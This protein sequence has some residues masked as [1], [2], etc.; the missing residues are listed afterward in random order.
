MNRTGVRGKSRILVALGLILGALL[1]VGGLQAQPGER[2]FY[3]ALPYGSEATFN[4]LSTI[5]NGGYGNF[6]I[7]ERF[8]RPIFEVDYATGWRNV[9]WNLRHAGAAIR[10]FGWRDFL[11]NEVL[12]TTIARRGAQFFPN[13]QNHIIGGGATYRA[14]A[15]WFAVHHYPQPR[16]LAL[17]ALTA[18]HTLNEVVENDSYRGVNVDPIADMLIFNPLGVLLFSSDRVARFFGETLQLRDWA[19]FPTIDP[20]GGTLENNGQN[21][22]IKI[23][24]GRRSRWRLFYQFGVNGILGLSYQRAD[25]EAISFGGGLLAKNLR[26]VNR[27]DGIRVQTVDLVWNV[28]IFYDRNG[29]LLASVMASGGR[30]YRFRASLYPGVLRLGHFSPALFAALDARGRFIWGLSAPWLPLGLAA[31][32]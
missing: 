17:L 9:W 27:E 26:R 14:F 4:P 13:Y 29:S 12:P 25:G 21:F 19:F 10:A 8:A 16:L 3:H 11:R 5:V 2:F 28:G 31:S 24:L 1:K 20:F 22:A 18:Y 15:E 32:K 30:T 23:K 7:G 6:Q